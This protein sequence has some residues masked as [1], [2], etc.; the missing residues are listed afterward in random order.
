MAARSASPQRRFE[1]AHGP[2]VQLSASQRRLRKQSFQPC[3]N[4]SSSSGTAQE[5]LV[6]RIQG[7]EI[8]NIRDGNPLLLFA[9]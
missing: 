1:P 7:V 5:V 2:T 4:A 8:H 3:G 6:L 9:L